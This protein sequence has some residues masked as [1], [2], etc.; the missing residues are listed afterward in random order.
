MKRFIL[1]FFIVVS[2]L[3]ALGASVLYYNLNLKKLLVR[4]A[5]PQVAKPRPGPSVIPLPTVKQDNL[6]YIL[7]P[8]NSRRLISVSGELV[9]VILSD[10]GEQGAFRLIS[11]HAT[12]KG[13]PLVFKATLPNSGL[14]DNRKGAHQSISPDEFAAA[15]VPR[16]YV[17][18][19]LLDDTRLET[20]NSYLCH[21]IVL[22]N[23]L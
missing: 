14:I 15:S 21:T 7:G 11:V 9:N 16:T 2:L 13:K 10:P 17:Q 22:K 3:F 8:Q 4:P 19:N 5:S 6:E 20:G 18:C 12:H 23:N 1:L